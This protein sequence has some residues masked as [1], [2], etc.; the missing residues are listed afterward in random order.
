MKEFTLF[1]CLLLYGLCFSQSHQ[2]QQLTFKEGISQSEI[3]CFLEDSRGFMWFGTVDGLNRYDGYQVG[4]FHTDKNNPNSISHNTIRCLAEDELGRIWIGTDDGLCVYDTRLEKFFQIPLKEVNRS[5][6]TINTSLIYKGQLLIGT[7]MGLMM[8]NINTQELEQIERS[9]NLLSRAND[10]STYQVTAS[11]IGQDGII[12]LTTESALY[13]L[14]FSDPVNIPTLNKVL[15]LEEFLPDLRNLAEDSWGNLWIVSHDNGFVRYHLKTK[16]LKHFKIGPLNNSVFSNKI[17]CVRVDKVGNLWIGTHDKGLLFLEKQSLNEENPHFQLITHDPYNDRSLSS[18]LIYS[19]YVSKSNLLWIGTI[20]SGINIF[21][22]NRKPFHYFS[23]KN[24][25]TQSSYSTNFIRAVYADE[26]ENI[27]IGTHNNGLF[28]LN[29]DKLGSVEKLGFGTE[30]IFHLSDAGSGKIFVCTGRG[31][32][33]VKKDPYSPEILSTLAIGP[34]FYATQAKGDIFWVAS[35]N[36]VIKCSLQGDNIILEKEYTTET[37]PALSFNNCRVL[38]FNEES[39]QLF[40]GTEGGGLNI[41][42]LNED[43]VPVQSQVYSKDNSAST[44]SNNYIRS[45]IKSSRSDFWIGTYEGLNKME[46]D[47]ISGNIIFK[48]YTQE[49]GLPNNTVQSLTEDK[50]GNLWMGTNKGLCK[51]EPGSEIFTPYTVNDGIQSN[52]FS[53]HTIFK[54]SDGEIVI[55][56]I[57]GINTFYPGKIHS[58]DIKPRTTL[59]DF[60][61]FNKKISVGEVSEGGE[62]SPLKKS[63]TLSDSI[64]LKPHQNSIGFDFS[65]MNYNSPEKIQ[66][67]YLLDG[68]DKEWNITDAKNRKVIYTNLAFGQYTFKVMATNNDGEWEEAPKSIFISI[69]TPFYYTNWAFMLYALLAILALIFFTNYSILRIT[70]KEKIILE[71]QHNKKIR[72]LEELRARFFINISHDLRTPLTLISSP[73]ELILKNKGLQPEVVS[74]LDL[75]Q[76]NVKKLKDMTE[77]LL[78]VTKVETGKLSPKPQILDI[79]AFVRREAK[80]FDHAFRSKEIDLHITSDDPHKDL[81]FDPDMLSKVISNLLSNSLKYTQ[82]GQI[83]IHISQATSPLQEKQD[84]PKDEAWVAISIKDTG[85]GIEEAELHK[86]FDRFYQGKEQNK[87]GYGIGLSHSKDLIEAHNGHMEVLSKKGKGSTFTIFLP[88]HQ[89]PGESKKEGLAIA[90]GNGSKSIVPES[91]PMEIKEEAAFPAKE[92]EILLVEDNP[93][94]REFIGGEL[95]KR[96]KLLEAKDGQEGLELAQKHFPDL[97]ISDIMMP[98]MDGMEFCKE[99]KSDIQTSHIPVILLTAKVDRETKY[100]GLEIGADEYFSK[101]VEMDYLHLRI[102]NLLENRE[103]LRQKFQVN[104]KLEPSEVTV[105]SI[106]EQFLK[107]LMSE[108]EKGI[109]DSEFSINAL[110]L[111]LGM[112]HSSFYNKIKSLTGQSAK[113]LLLNMRMKRAKQILEDTPNIRISEVAYMVGFSDPKYFAKR[114]KE[115]FGDSPSAFVNKH[116]PT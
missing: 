6:L 108:I 31:V 59:T 100:A 43:M 99:I 54:K 94:L 26:K 87:T 57:N 101:P 71:N 77:Q 19:L 67:A 91:F 112:S 25:A 63:I 113:E 11:L 105:T 96:Y 102:R 86:V 81:S 116:F 33:L 30:S 92:K 89:Y 34:T 36:G 58:S 84:S 61:L 37:Q 9:V 15:D 68:F 65:A 70:T 46:K 2:F 109:P 53:E 22:P 4:V 7:S 74:L 10:T 29:R 47:P 52:E 13:R 93:D 16:K 8:L 48:I 51:F 39:H 32:S 73:L 50:Q 17:S 49:D 83:S 79:V 97:I 114:F 103:R 76:R 75:V 45:I 82:E 98:N 3:Y 5:R 78:D 60:Y 38:Y 28:F 115:Y 69:K 42:S 14:P 88:D 23:L 66:Y 64:F 111:E 41:F 106:D 56:G 110:E 40:I 95:R 55:G 20:G 72:E 44:I 107:K 62:K 24:A 12:W 90:S 85:S 27:W 21:N 18:N 1:V 104:V 35:L 80:L